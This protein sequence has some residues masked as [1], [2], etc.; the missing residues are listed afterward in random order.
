MAADPSISPATIPA[1]HDAAAG[2]TIGPYKLLELIAEGGFGE[3]WLAERRDPMVQRVALKIIKAGMDTKAVVARFEQERQALAVMDHTNIARVYD[4]G[5]TPHGRPYFV[6]ELVAGEPITDYCDRHNLTIRQ[7]LE[8]FIP[9]CEAVQHAHHKGI[10]HR[11]IKPSNILV[12]VHERQPVPKV[13]DFGIAKATSRTLAE[14]TIFTE[15]GQ[16]IGTPEY[17]SPEQ[18]EMGALDIDTRTDVYSLGVV[19]YELLAGLLPFD[20]ASLRAAGYDAIRKIIRDQEPARPSTRLSTVDNATGAEIA[21]HRQAH[22]GL[23]AKE[24]RR[25]LDWIPLRALR[26]DRT[27]RYD[28]PAS[29]AKDIE[30]YL[31]GLPLEAG[32]VSSSY[33]I[34]KFIR[35]H[36]AA[37]AAAAAMAALLV[38]GIAGTAWGLWRAELRRAD[39]V[40]A[41]IAKTEALEAQAEAATEAK[42]SAAD[43]IA[44][45]NQ[46]QAERNA[47]RSSAYSACIAAAVDAWAAGD[48]DRLEKSLNAAPE[49]LRAWEF[50]FLHASLDCSLRSFDQA[51]ITTAT[52]WDA[53]NN[54]VIFANASGQLR[55]V[56]NGGLGDTKALA[57][58]LSWPKE[59]RVT[60][61]GWH[62]LVST[63]DNGLARLDLR[64]GGL[65]MYLGRVTPSKKSA[66]STPAPLVTGWTV[67]EGGPW[68]VLALAPDAEHALLASKSKLIE[69]ATA[70]PPE[71]RELKVASIP[72]TAT[73]VMDGGRSVMLIGPDG[74]VGIQSCTSDDPISSL[75]V[76]A[77]HCS[78]LAVAPYKEMFAT[79][80]DGVV[81]LHG[82]KD[83]PDRNRTLHSKG[84][85]AWVGFVPSTN[86]VVTAGPETDPTI[87]LWNSDSG[88][89]VAQFMGHRTSSGSPEVRVFP[90]SYQRGITSLA[91]SPTGESAVSGATDGAR[92]WG[93]RVWRTLSVFGPTR[94]NGAKA[95]S[96][97]GRL[98]AAGADKG[99]INLF[100]LRTRSAPRSVQTGTSTIEL[101][102]MSAEG[103]FIAVLADDKEVLLLDAK[104]GNETA[105]IHP[106]GNRVTNIAMNRQGTRIATASQGGE[107]S[108]WDARTGSKI[109]ELG[110]GMNFGMPLAFSP[111]GATLASGGMNEVDL[112]E[113]QTGAASSKLGPTGYYCMNIAFSPDGK[114]IATGTRGDSANDIRIFDRESKSQTALLQGHR[115]GLLG[116]AFTHDGRRLLSS[117]GDLTLRCWDLEASAE[118]AVFRLGFGFGDLE[119]APDDSVLA[120]GSSRGITIMDAAP[121]TLTA[122]N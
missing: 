110:K 66:E 43:A 64:D 103:D 111:D 112:W 92:L 55:I 114:Q 118:I 89:E 75:D 88:E 47:A 10:I 62:A 29:L 83:H 51:G 18:A 81:S 115:N 78:M 98:L 69:V 11:D 87:R 40:A 24:L 46:A 117:S 70:D 33:R 20:S 50:R 45:R 48:R 28:S 13:I 7:R 106:S 116:L 14:K 72:R 3:V 97:D 44:A 85:V 80:A 58:N 38:C 119:L 16:L 113:S 86:E 34:G 61:D 104:S 4:A 94:G 52:A 60:K 90:G 122:P 22:R 101:I 49:S 39:A 31:N 12:S 8:L 68:S 96:A 36:K 57:T 1:S 100:D 21:Q 56:D 99:V 37:V 26:K 79:L 23:L 84:E 65:A 42:L 71:V 2:A 54:R 109:A 77:P 91:V 107:F 32:P 102:Q 105:R 25:E 108:L 19:L 93:L 15:T 120:F 121:H 95:L 76:H 53:A 59:I 6:M 17:M 41:N 30:R 9:V 63:Y 5:A 73:Y 67:P 35:R 82:F 74:R 27:E